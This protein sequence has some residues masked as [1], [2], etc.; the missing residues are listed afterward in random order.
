M[1]TDL[2]ELTSLH[3]DRAVMRWI[4]DPEPGEQVAAALQRWS[5]PADPRFGVWAAESGGGRFV[6]WFSLEVRQPATGV[7]GYRLHRWAW[8]RGLATEGCRAMLGWAFTGAD[9]ARVVAQTYEDN[10][11][12]RR[13]MEKL[14]MRL[15]ARFRLDTEALGGQP[16][17]PGDEV[18]YAIGAVQWF[19]AGAAP[20]RESSMLRLG[21]Q[22]SREGNAHRPADPGASSE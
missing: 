14:G 11:A 17:W 9:L 15:L 7:L 6:G 16:E 4:G 12:S 3:T 1:G 13:V 19:D 8:G 18:A 20:A 10:L 2:P 21:S 22:Q 5:Q